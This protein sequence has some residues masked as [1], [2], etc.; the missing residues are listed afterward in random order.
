MLGVVYVGVVLLGVAFFPCRGVVEFVVDGELVYDVLYYYWCYCI[1]RRCVH[2]GLALW[3][4]LLRSL[5]MR[6]VAW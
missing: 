1:S 5:L 4:G 2:R 3:R 6:V